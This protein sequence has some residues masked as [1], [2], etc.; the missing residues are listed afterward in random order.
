M[1]EVNVYTLDTMS[2]WGVPVTR[3]KVRASD[4]RQL[5]WAEVHAAFTGV[6]PDQW[7][8]QFFPPPSETVDEANVYHLWMFPVDV[9]GRLVATRQYESSGG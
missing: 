2:F 5:P 4:Y 7:A 8:M 9:P 3:L 1:S 6:Y